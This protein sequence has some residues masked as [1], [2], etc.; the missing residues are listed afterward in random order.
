MRS[1]NKPRAL[2]LVGALIIAT[3]P[4]CAGPSARPGGAYRTDGPEPERVRLDPRA[5]A[6][7]LVDASGAS[8]G[9]CVVLGREDTDLAV[10]ISKR[11]RFVVHALYP[12]RETVDQARKS[13][14]SRG[15]Y[16]RVSADVSG[17]RRLPYAQNLVNVI[18]I[19]RFPAL[20][21]LGLS[22]EEVKR[23]LCPLG[24]VFFAVGS[25]ADDAVPARARE[26]ESAL[27]AA[28]FGGVEIIRQGGTWVKAVR[29][30][31]ADIDEW[32]HYLH[33]ADGN[34]VAN[35]S[36]VGPPRHQ[37]WVS[38]PRW[39]RSHETVSSVSTIV[40][41]RGRLFYIADEAPISLPGMH[42]LPDKWALVA[43][44]AFN[45]VQ[46]WRVPIGQWGWRQWKTSWFS[47]RPGDYPFN[48]Q[49]RLVAA[50]D[51]VYV[52][53]GYHAPLSELDA[54]TGSLLKTYE[55]TEDTVEFLYVDRVASGSFNRA[56]RRGGVLVCSVF[57][58]GALRLSA[59]DAAGGK[60]L[61]TT[62]ESYRG[63]TTD[64]LKWRAMRGAIKR[65][66]KL[67]PTLNTATDGR[68][69]AFLDGNAVVAVSFRDGTEK[70]RAEFPEKG[71][72]SP[73]R[74]LPVHG[75][76]VG[77][78][79]VKDG[80]VLHASPSTLACFSASDGKLRWTRPKRYLGH[81]WYAWK[82][83]FVI[84]GL[85]WTWSDR[86]LREPLSAPAGKKTAGRSSWPETVNG[87][88]LR[89]G[90]LE[91][92]VDLGR[93]FKTH[94]HHRCYRNKATVRYILASRRGTEY[95]DL[96]GGK[97]SVHN[98]VRGTCHVGMMPANGLHYAP[99]HPCVCY[100]AEKLNGM[101]ALAPALPQ[102]TG[103][104]P[105]SPGRMLERG[106]AWGEVEGPPARDED[107]P[108]YRHDIGRSGSVK[109][110][111]PADAG[112]VW[113][114]QLGRPSPR[115]RSPP[116]EALAKEGGRSASTSRGPLQGRRA[117]H[118]A[119]QAPSGGLWLPPRGARARRPARS[120]RRA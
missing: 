106:P 57:G 108:T 29:P 99:P 87:Y 42:E 33:G 82:D 61:W 10:A 18:V 51:R 85:V 113:R 17:Y 120:T 39:L 14:R 114:V 77:T 16:G 100:S 62:R 20:K 32:T 111:L 105:E 58:G 118:P 95:V 1:R 98:W 73:V 2:R 90:K 89:T 41:A 30:W 64:Y 116:S 63:V 47:P 104:A 115:L 38:G 71:P 109:T 27:G 76:W 66:A 45:G 107:W 25:A 40:T 21:G 13:I 69:V 24:T 96:H 3:I 11:G 78:T 28:G 112:V 4:A 49:K 70:W 50:G 26:L 110:R 37:Q 5:L 103:L 9:V 56:T 67:A 36:V 53:L 52:T 79:I 6:E 43:R 88:D 44:D 48:I 86:L 97:H 46:L 35:D 7:R 19:D 12:D 92:K 23:V 75:L 8:G 72:K 68:T 59:V 55:G 91:R 94:H 102:E 54:R 65:P 74:G 84:D 34:P 83:V 119:G 81:L 31:P 22:L 101:N 15:A 60:R 93:I 80:C 117:R